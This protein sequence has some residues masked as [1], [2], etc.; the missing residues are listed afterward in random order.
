KGFTIEAMPENF[1]IKN[2]FGFYKTEY[3]VLNEN[4]LLYKRTFQTNSGNYDKSEYENFRKFR[5]QVSKNDNAKIA[6]AKN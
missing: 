2:N 5:E 3:I 1:E 4:Q 6:L